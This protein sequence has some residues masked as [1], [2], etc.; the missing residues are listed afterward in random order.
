MCCVVCLAV[1]GR[2][3]GKESFYSAAAIFHRGRKRRSK[4]NSG[5]IHQAYVGL[6]SKC[7]GLCLLHGFLVIYL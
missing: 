5:K 7:N 3:G 1:K 4:K 2:E 6:L